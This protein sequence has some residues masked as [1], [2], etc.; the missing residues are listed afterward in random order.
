MLTIKISANPLPL[1]RLYPTNK[2]GRRF[3]SKEGQEY[4]RAVQIATRDAY[5]EQGFK[6]NPET[7][8]ISSEVFYYMPKLI[9]KARKISL[10]KPDTS[11]LF[12]ALEDSVF[13]TLGID[14]AYNLDITA[15]VHYSSEPITIL[16]LRTH[17]LSAKFDNH[18]S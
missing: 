15:T 10:N 2:S 18:L 6:F 7:H 3:L 16:I 4:K 9:T 11:N 5:L 12:K 17:Q 14:D 1:N 13:E 8:Y